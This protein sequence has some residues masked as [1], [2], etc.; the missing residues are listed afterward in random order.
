MAW[1][2]SAQHASSSSRPPRA[3]TSCRKRKS[4]ARSQQ[5]GSEIALVLWPGVQYRTGQAF[6]LARIARAARRKRCLV[7]FD[8]AHSIGNTPLAAHDSTAPIS[9]SGAATSISMPGPARS[10]DASS[11]NGIWARRP[12]RIL[13]AGGA[14]RPQRAFSCAP[15]FTPP[16]AQPGWQISNP[17]I[18]SAAPLVASLAIFIEARHASA[19]APSRSAL[20][21][22]LEFLLRAAGAGRADH[23]AAR[24]GGARLP[25]LTARSRRARASS[26][27]WARPAWC[28]TGASRTPCGSRPCRST[29]ASRMSGASAST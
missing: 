2:R 16:P 17:P 5:L 29:T 23:H 8:L 24:T 14:T 13:P 22:F 6:D 15:N 10:A 27:A 12:A 3:K 20:T 18:L 26:S 7:G 25:A 9:P 28:A 1:P 19:C 4:R 21:A 11:T